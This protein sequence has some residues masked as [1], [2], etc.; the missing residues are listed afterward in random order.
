MD[1]HEELLSSISTGESVVN[2]APRRWINPSARV[3]K[4]V[5]YHNRDIRFSHEVLLDR[6]KKKNTVNQTHLSAVT[7]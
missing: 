7:F 1:T 5:I 2:Y 3:S 6:G 4:R